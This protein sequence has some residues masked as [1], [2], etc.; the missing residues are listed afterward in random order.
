MPDKAAQETDPLAMPEDGTTQD[1]VDFL[2]KLSKV[3][4]GNDD[5][6]KHMRM[7][8]LQAAEKILAAD[9]DEQQ[10]KLAVG[11]KA[12]ALIDDLKALNKF[13][14]QLKKDGHEKLAHRVHGFALMQKIRLVPITN[15]AS[16]KPRA[17]EIVEFLAEGTTSDKV[18]VQLA[19]IAGQMAEMV[20]NQQFAVDTYGKIQKLFLASDDPRAVRFGQAMEGTI[21]RASLVGNPMTIEGRIFR[22]DKPFDWAQYRG[23]VVLVNFFA[24]WCKPC[25]HEIENLQKVYKAYHDKG[26]EVIGVSCDRS[27]PALEEFLKSKNLPWPVVYGDNEPSPTVNYYGISGIPQLILVGKD[28]RVLSLNVRSNQLPKELDKLLGSTG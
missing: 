25:R 2:I 18:D 28:G 14:A 4:P 1:Y 26:F 6:L 5:E 8:M 7:V 15:R 17:E 16:L 13:I 9:P 20:G 23:K 10:L 22:D 19:N 24:T 21:R 3:K 12:L 11:A 27:G